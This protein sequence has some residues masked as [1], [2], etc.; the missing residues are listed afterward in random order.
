MSDQSAD[1][2]DFTR[3]NEGHN[4]IA[5][6]HRN[7]AIEYNKFRNLSAV[8]TN[9]AILATLQ[10]I[11]TRQ[12]ASCVLSTLNISGIVNTNITYVV[13]E[14]LFHVFKTLTSKMLAVYFTQCS[15]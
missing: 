6:A 7:L 4:Q 1:Q 10:R 15:A 14:M 11:E 13:S 5:Q 9:A 12:I 8:E 3:I 2:P